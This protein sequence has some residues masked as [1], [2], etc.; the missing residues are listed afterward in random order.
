MGD[1]GGER[2]FHGGA[3]PVVERPPEA[4]MARWALAQMIIAG[5]S[6]AVVLAAILWLFVLLAA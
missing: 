2:P 5:I 4:P 1:R 6:I 3:Q